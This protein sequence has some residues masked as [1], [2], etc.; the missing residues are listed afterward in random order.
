MTERHVRNTAR[1]LLYDARGRVLLFLT[2]YSENID[3]PP[4][5]ITPGGGI[6]P[7][8]T[9]EVAARRE[10]FEETGL[11]VDGVGRMVWE[12]DFERRRIDGALDVGHSTFFAVR[13]DE[14][15]P[16]SDNWMPEEF[17]DI[18]AHRWWSAEEL[19]AEAAPFEPA[20][21]PELIRRHS[22]SA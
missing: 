21:L 1:V 16:L 3:R 13:T 9:P 11:T 18:H 4:R 15:A 10:L 22:P 19:E 20:E 7:G 14:F 6:D 2:N 8:E 17:D 12:H 5:W